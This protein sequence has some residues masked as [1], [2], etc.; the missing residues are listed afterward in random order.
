M[1]KNP[2]APHRLSKGKVF[3]ANAKNNSE[4]YFCRKYLLNLR[5]IHCKKMT[6]SIEYR[7]FEKIKKY[8]KGSVFFTD[9]F[10]RFGTAKSAGKTLERL[11]RKGEI[12][13]IARGIY[14]RPEKS[15]TLGITLT[16]SAET[17]VK[18]IARRDR[19]RIVPTG[20]HALHML[21]LST[22]VPMNAVYLTDG[23]ARKIVIGK[24]IIV[25]K[26]TA[27][28]NLSAIGEIS[29]LVIQGLKAIG[30]DALTEEEHAKI[31]ELLKKEKTERL[32]HDI[33][34]APEWIRTIMRTALPENQNL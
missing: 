33:R 10:L 29:G 14:T 6:E 15:K 11:A 21:G 9:D 26:K 13:R 28:K 20:S 2:Q 16:P 19:A 4:T 1:N 31:I 30:K 5:Q 3:S 18:A 17:I 34:L 24:R 22:Q 27:P 32:L 23:A 12:M 7:V 8:K 25:F